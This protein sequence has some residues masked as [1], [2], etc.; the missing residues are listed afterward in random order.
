MRKTPQHFKRREIKKVIDK[1]LGDS[2]LSLTPV[3]ISV[4]ELFNEDLTVTEFSF[5]TASRGTR[6]TVSKRQKGKGFIDGLFSGL[7]NHFNNDY[8]SL[9]KI[10]LA[11]FDVNPII[12]NFQSTSGAD[13]Q[14]SVSLSVNIAPHGISEFQHKS[15]SVIYSSFTTALEAFQFYINCERSFHKIQFFLNHAQ[16]RNRSDVANQYVYDL[17]KLTEVNT[18]EKKKKD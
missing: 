4:K 14:A 12:S 16:E 10:R 9:A 6:D 1:I 5:D 11:D 15:R 3:S 7:Q 18:Y 13:A 2:K 17:S 8:S